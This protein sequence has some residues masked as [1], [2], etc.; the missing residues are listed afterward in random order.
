MSGGRSPRGR[1]AGRRPQAGLW[2]AV[3]A[4]AAVALALAIGISVARDRT[5]SLE[6]ATAL[7]PPEAREPL[8][9]EGRQHIPEGSRASYRTDPPTSGPHYATWAEPAFYTEPVPY[10]LLVHNLEHG[11]VVIYYDPARTPTGARDHLRRLTRRYRH[12]WAAVLAVPREDPRYVLIL[13][14]WRHW[15][16]LERYDPALVDAFVEVYR[17]RGPERPVR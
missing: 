1:P 2:L 6:E 3:A 7:L 5:P 12:P 10:E 9:D 16:R 13:T 14:A 11:H 4:A 15:L 8:P 17:G